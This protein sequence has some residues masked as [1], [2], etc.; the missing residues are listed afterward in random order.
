[1]R[2]LW[3]LA[4]RLVFEHLH[5]LQMLGFHSVRPSVELR[6]DG[7]R[8]AFERGGTGDAIKTSLD[9][10]EAQRPPVL[11]SYSLERRPH[12]APSATLGSFSAV[13]RRPSAREA[14][15]LWRREM[16]P[17]GHGVRQTP[18]AGTAPTEPPIALRPRSSDR[19]VRDEDAVVPIG[20]A[21][22]AAAGIDAAEGS[23]GA[24]AGLETDPAVLRQLQLLSAAVDALSLQQHELAKCQHEISRRQET[25]HH[26]LMQLLSKLDRSHHTHM[27]AI[28]PGEGG[29]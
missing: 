27:Q 19:A 13:L 21:P 9:A 4:R 5:Q 20:I 6:Q 7:V 8:N 12:D 14:S 23:A 28:G 16:A 25:H 24:E 18:I 26:E 10:S 29:F 17:L 22:G 3:K 15:T 11:L 2:A 1:M